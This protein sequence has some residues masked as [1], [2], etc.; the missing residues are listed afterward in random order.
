MG[1]RIDLTGKHIGKLVFLKP[2]K[3]LKRRTRWLCRCDCGREKT[4]VTEAVIYGR[5]KS[6]G[7]LLKNLHVGN[8]YGFKHGMDGTREYDTWVNMIQRCTN[9]KVTRWKY[10][11]GRGIKV[12]VRWLK[13][14]ENFYSDMG[15]RPEGK[16]LDRRDNDGD[17]S[18]ANC[19]WATPKEQEHNKQRHRP[20]L[21]KRRN[22]HTL[23]NNRRPRR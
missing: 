13:S 9:P 23:L 12:C 20:T 1:S 8:K 22:Q 11:G 5:T 3:S 14:F 10:Y 17:Y 6:C 21:Q 4:I 15:A 16:T 19:R 18:P 7:C 2:A